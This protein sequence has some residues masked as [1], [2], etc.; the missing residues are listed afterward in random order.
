VSRHV[1][2]FTGINGVKGA[3]TGIGGLVAAAFYVTFIDL[4]C[5]QQLALKSA[6]EFPGRFLRLCVSNVYYTASVML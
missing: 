1:L 2:G 5:L 6:L 3:N 4:K